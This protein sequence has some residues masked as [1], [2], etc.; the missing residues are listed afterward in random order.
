[1]FILTIAA[2]LALA[3]AAAVYVMFEKSKLGILGG[4]LLFALVFIFESFTIV[5]P[6]HVGVQ[7]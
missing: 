5:S 4:A 1:M 7:S 3:I 6:G 2:I